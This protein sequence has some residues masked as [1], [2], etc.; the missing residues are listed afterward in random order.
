MHIPIFRSNLG[1]LPPQFNNQPQTG[2]IPAAIGAP[3]PGGTTGYNPVTPDGGGQI[4]VGD[5]Q[6]SWGSVTFVVGTEPIKI[7]DQLLR[8]F[9]TLQNKSGTGTIFVGF[10]WVP[11]TEN[12]LELPP[13]VGYEP[14]RYPINDIWVVGSEADIHGVLIFGT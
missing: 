8:K 5:N 12:G 11:N 10:G 2:E 7:Q 9:L 4:M 1:D 3:P 14:F 6:S 13:G